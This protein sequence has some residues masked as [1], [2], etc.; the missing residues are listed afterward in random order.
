MATATADKL[1]TELMGI[2]GAKK[3]ENIFPRLKALE[4]L[5]MCGRCCGT[6]HYS[7]N[8]MTGTTCFG[9]QGRQFLMPKVTR[10]LVEAVRAKWTAEFAAEYHA[11]LAADA[12]SRKRVESARGMYLASR[13]VKALQAGCEAARERGELVGRYWQHECEWEKRNMPEAAARR[14]ELYTIQKYI[15][16]AL[17]GVVGAKEWDKATRSYKPADWTAIDARLAP[18]LAQFEALDSQTV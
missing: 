12:A 16:K 1:T 18:L 10:N 4:L 6:G 17:E 2:L 15:D 5:D 9:C 13:T 11:K 3:P 7:Y 8:A 14:S